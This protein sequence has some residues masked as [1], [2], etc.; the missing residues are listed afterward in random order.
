MF[1]ALVPGINGSLALTL[2]IPLTFKM[3]AFEAITLMAAVVGGGSFA[4]SIAAILLNVP[5]EAPNAA[6]A[7][8]GYALSRQGKAA[9]A[10][11]VSA[12]ASAMGALFG[13][14]VLVLLLPVARQIIFAFSFPEFFLLAFL[15]LAIISVAARGTLLKGFIAG[16]FGMLLSFVGFDP[17]TGELRYVFDRPYLYDG[18]RI[19]PVIIGLF[20]VA[21]ALRLLLEKEE[22][23]SAVEASR[24]EWPQLVEGILFVFRHFG[25]FLRSS[26]IGTVIGIIPGVGGSVASFVAYTSAVQTAKDPE[27]FGRGDPRGVLAPEAANDAK[28]GGAA[29]PTLAFGIPGSSDWAIALGAMVL[30]GLQPGP[31]LLREHA[32]TIWGII[33]TLVLASQATSLVGLLTAP[34]A[35]RLTRIRIAILAPLILVMVAVSTYAIDG[36]LGDMLMAMAFGVIGYYMKKFNVPAVP[37]ILGLLLGGLAE[38]SLYQT[39]LWSGGRLWVVGTR[40]V[41]LVLIALIAMTLA[42][43]FLALR[44]GRGDPGVAKQ[45]WEAGRP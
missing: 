28:N 5:G 24:F 44:R 27:R 30:H 8:D 45:Q 26:V 7:L 36:H 23:I 9:M 37:L 11:A 25:L 35:V 41:S 3:G 32:D 10:L 1:A 31:L 14:L 38:R 22:R 40:P 21:E 42:T 29:L 18:V 34:W 15:G 43:P 20:G 4:G 12:T 13:I 17:F 2:L 6:T 33:W 19:V 16:G 39:I